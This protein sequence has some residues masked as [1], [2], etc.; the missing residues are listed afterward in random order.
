[1][2]SGCLLHL[3]HSG[4]VKLPASILKQ[5]ELVKKKKKYQ[6]VGHEF[7]QLLKRY[8]PWKSL[9]AANPDI[10]PYSLRHGYA[11]RAVKYDHYN[12]AVPP[13]DL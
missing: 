1:M 8:K 3:Y 13:L 5:I 6:D 7:G 10:T 12:K 2:Q 11:W 4:L 9:V